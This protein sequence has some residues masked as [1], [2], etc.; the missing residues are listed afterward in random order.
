MS[1]ETLN[2]IKVLESEI[3]ELKFAFESLIDL[4]IKLQQELRTNGSKPK[5]KAQ[6]K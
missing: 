3:K 5:A 1:I 6:Q 2:R 4:V